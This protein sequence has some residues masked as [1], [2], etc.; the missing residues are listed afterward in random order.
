[1]PCRSH[2]DPVIEYLGGCC[3]EQKIL[4]PWM[5]TTAFF[6]SYPEGVYP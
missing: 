3:T 2:V 5:Y 6:A 4:M 1:M